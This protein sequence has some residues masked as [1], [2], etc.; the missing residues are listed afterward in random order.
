MEA[1]EQLQVYINAQKNVA[2]QFMLIGG[3]LLLAAALFHFLGDSELSMGIRMGA[4][5][6]GIFIFSGGWA[7]RNT[8]NKLLETQTNIHQESEAEFFKTEK[9][10]MIKVEKDYPVY[11]YVFGAFILLS[12]LVI[13]FVASPYWKGVAFSVAFLFLMVMIVEAFSQNSIQAYL[14]FVSSR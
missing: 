12:L 4:L 1:L 5:I 13:W 10:R 7:Y 6:G 3:V 2:H 8:E 11:Q 9:E 14:R